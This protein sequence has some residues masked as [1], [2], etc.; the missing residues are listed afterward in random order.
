MEDLSADIKKLQETLQLL[1]KR[2]KQLQ[3][4]NED[5]KSEMEGLKKQLSEKNLLIE[6][7]QEKNVAENIALL[8]NSEE[9]RI[10]KQKI[11]FYLK[12]IERCFSLLNA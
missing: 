2:Y 12:D 5:L 3:R 6:N 7:V 8:Y 1:L 4:E 10:L 9:K 11:D